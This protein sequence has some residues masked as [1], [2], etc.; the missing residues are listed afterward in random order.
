MRHVASYGMVLSGESLGTRLGMQRVLSSFHFR[1]V[2]GYD[3]GNIRNPIV[4]LGSGAGGIDE[5]KA[6]C[7]DDAVVY[8][9]YRV[10]SISILGLNNFGGLFPYAYAHT[11]LPSHVS[12]PPTYHSSPTYHSPPLHMCR[13]M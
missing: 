13:R 9:F 7:A 1:C 8:G 12:L 11:S 5:L 4:L 6:L 2:A 3:G 10:V